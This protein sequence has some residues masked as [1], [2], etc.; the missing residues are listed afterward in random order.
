VLN[1]IS[2]TLTQKTADG[3]FISTH[4]VE[5][6][7]WTS[8]TSLA[9]L[10]EVG[11]DVRMFVHLYH[12][13]TAMHLY[14]FATAMERAL[15][16]EL[17]KVDGTGPRLALRILSGLKPP[18]LLR[19]VRDRDLAAL[20]RVPGIGRKTAEKLVIALADKPILE[21][22]APA[23]HPLKPDLVGALIGMGFDRREAARALDACWEKLASQGLSPEA[24]E[25]EALREAIRALGEA[26]A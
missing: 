26:R 21:A 16:L 13:E 20:S 7:I 19:A 11:R 23:D 14:G 4:G 18:E 9:E 22:A 25:R 2:G 1:S 3:A 5:W 12:R 10:P 24:L 8:A 17:L 15:F 6:E